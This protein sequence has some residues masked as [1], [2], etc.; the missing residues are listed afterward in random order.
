[1]RRWNG[2]GDERTMYPLRESARPWLY[3]RVGEPTRPPDTPLSELTQQIPDSP[4]RPHPLLTFDP[5][6]RLRH[7]R[8]Q[9]FPDWVALRCGRVPIFPAAIAYPENE[10]H[11]HTLIQYAQANGAVLIPY[12]GGTSVV[13]GINPEPDGPA[14]LTVD[15][16]QLNQLLQLN[17]TA[18]LATFGAGISGPDLEA[19]LNPQGY[20]LGHF[21]QSFELSTLGGWIATRSSGQQ[22]LYYGRIEDTF[23]GGRLIT[24]A[25]VLEMPPFPASAAGPDWRHLVLGSEGRLG[26][27]SQATV[28]ITPLPEA[29]SF[30]GIF[31]P[32]W[33]QGVAAV[34]ELAQAQLPLSMLRLSNPLETEANLILGGKTGQVLWLNRGLNWLGQRPQEKCLLLMGV[35]GDAAAHNHTRRAALHLTRQHGG[36]SLGQLLGRAWQKG[37]FLTPYLRNTLWEL[38]YGVDTLESAFTWDQVI[39]AE[40]AI[41]AA[42]HQA[43]AA[44]GERVLVIAHLS[45]VYP[46]GSSLYVTYLFRLLPDPDQLLAFWGAMKA[47]ASQAIITHRGTITH[48][49]GVGTDHAPYLQAEKGELGLNLLT[50][51]FHQ[52]DPDG[53]MN[54]GK[55]LPHR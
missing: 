40:A 5:Q 51:L 21:P 22:S 13:G 6:E 48:Q 53:V 50:H 19:Q 4:L 31:F 27:I 30:L 26:I 54:P 23:A 41:M 17:K 38:G 34:K 46:T 18:Q 33:E 15:L 29:E 42:I 12:G 20:T 49:H 24:P 47:A 43:A 16:S 8:G 9:S 32:T 10:A 1:M 35:T 36:V 52:A 44:Y 39:P 45:H 11:L 7:A 28:R 55:L 3:E 25:G 14:A 37:R 2:W